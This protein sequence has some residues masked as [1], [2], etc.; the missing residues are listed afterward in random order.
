[1]KP[2]CLLALL[3][4]VSCQKPKHPTYTLAVKLKPLAGEDAK[5]TINWPAIQ[6]MIPPGCVIA[7]N[8]EG[9]PS[10]YVLRATKHFDE[11]MGP[12][13]YWCNPKWERKP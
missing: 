2:L 3:C 13:Y 11:N 4:A 7:G 5:V 1:V 9:V 10:G 8:T 12:P 6:A